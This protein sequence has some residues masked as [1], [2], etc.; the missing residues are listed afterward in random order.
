MA[1]ALC[2]QFSEYA[3]AGAYNRTLLLE[4]GRFAVQRFPEEVDVLVAVARMYIAADELAAA[5]AILEHA[6][7]L[8]PLD[9]RVARLFAGVLL[10]EG[11]SRRAEATIEGAIARGAN[12]AEMRVFRASMREFVRAQKTHG[13]EAIPREVKRKL[14]RAA[15]GV[16][17]KPSINPALLAAPPPEWTAPFREWA[18]AIADSAEP[19]P[20]AQ[21]PEPAANFVY[22]RKDDRKK[23]KPPE[24]DAPKEA[25]A[26]RH[27]PPRESTATEQNAASIAAAPTLDQRRAKGRGLT[28]TLVTLL[29]LALIAVPVAV[30]LW[31]RQEANEKDAKELCYQAAAALSAGG[32]TATQVVNDNL[33]RALD[34]APSSAEVATCLTRVRALEVLE[35]EPSIAGEL[36]KMISGAEDLGASDAEVAYLDV[37]AAVG[38]RD[39][40]RAEALVARYDQDPARRVHAVYELSAGATMELVGDARAVDRYKAALGLESSL[41]AAQVRLARALLLGGAYAQGVIRV[42][43]LFQTTPGRAETR[44]LDALASYLDPTRENAGQVPL[45]LPPPEE[46]PVTLRGIARALSATFAS[47]RSAR[48]AA[49]AMAVTETDAPASAVFCGTLALRFGE[50]GVARDA[51]T[52]AVET[53]PTYAPAHVLAARVALL[54]GRAEE[55]Q[56][57]LTGL[58]GPAV[59]AVRALVAYE[60][61]D[62]QRLAE[63]AGLI[64]NPEAIGYAIVSAAQ[65]RT[66]GERALSVEQIEALAV[67]RDVWGPIIAMDGALDRGD[68]KLAERLL[69]AHADIFATPLGAQRRGRLLRYEGKLDEARKVLAGAPLVRPALIER[70]FLDAEVPAERARA[71]TSLGERYEP[72]R[73]WVEAYLNGRTSPAKAAPILGKLKVPAE[74][75]P[76]SLR[77]TAALAMST[78]RDLRGADL[79]RGL[80]ASHRQNPD[81]I[82]AAVGVGLLPASALKPAKGP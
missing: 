26:P 4:A 66:R 11:D 34:L 8:D 48:A 37:V 47:D 35:Q 74:N 32:P 69:G 23:D 63:L 50:I 49:F 82:R 18:D 19:P 45:D 53:A 40:S 55:A 77:L 51:A 31:Q 59:S 3:E 1:I 65:E 22:V 24:D 58:D 42:Q 39:A 21:A 38:T 13:R 7:R 60:T 54:E 28:R 52:R 20:V 5:H 14:S 33:A 44:T 62:T 70:A 46:L 79:V 81:V 73:K 57:Q 36:Q 56:R 29:A 17:H 9:S 2:A 25:A 64:R 6:Q 80:I 12:D 75:E 76:F 61:A 16:G 43:E 67:R 41:F 72:E 78:A 10:G 30:A 27:E 15:A 68:L 71:L